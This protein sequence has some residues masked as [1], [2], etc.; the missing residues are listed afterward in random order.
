MRWIYR[1]D[2]VDEVEAAVGGSWEA[3]R[4]LLGGKGANLG[5]MSRLGVPV[6][7]GFTIT[8]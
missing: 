6:P 5:E 8:T 7:P 4:A 1:F 3:V 2:E